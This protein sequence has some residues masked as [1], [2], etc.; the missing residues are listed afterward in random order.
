MWAAIFMMSF[1]ALYEG[2]ISVTHV[3]K[4]LFKKEAI[5]D[6]CIVRCH[7]EAETA[8]KAMQD[9]SLDSS[10]SGVREYPNSTSVQCQATSV[11]YESHFLASD[12]S[13]FWRKHPIS[14]FEKFNHPIGSSE[15]CPSGLHFPMERFVGDL[16]YGSVVG[17]KKQRIV[18]SLPLEPNGPKGNYISFKDLEK[19]EYTGINI[20]LPFL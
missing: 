2:L 16:I 1:L 17:K 20:A 3:S 14:S 10:C 11:S 9:C 19:L 8:M 5:E 15:R 18:G 7:G 4:L 12:R 13:E 6:A